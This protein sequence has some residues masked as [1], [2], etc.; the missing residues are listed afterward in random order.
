MHAGGRHTPERSSITLCDTC[1]RAPGLRQA[2]VRAGCGVRVP[3]YQH[4]RAPFPCAPPH[5]ATRNQRG[6]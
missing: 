2:P 1:K 4:G 3:G 6:P 5:A